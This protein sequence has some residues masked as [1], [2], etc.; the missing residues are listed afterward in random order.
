MRKEREQQQHIE[1]E[2]KDIQTH[3]YQQARCDQGLAVQ[4]KEPW[5][6]SPSPCRAGPTSHAVT[7]GRNRSPE[8]LKTSS[9][10]FSP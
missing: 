4:G 2:H 7:W 9:G 6:L 10:Q 1:K 3:G 8:G 5:L